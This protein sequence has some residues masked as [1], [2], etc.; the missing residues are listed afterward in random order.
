MAF[1]EAHGITVRET[2]SATKIKKGAP[3]ALE[4]LDGMERLVAVR[5][6]KRVEFDLVSERP[7]EDELLKHM[8]GPTGNLRAPTLKRGKQ[9]LVGFQAESYGTFLGV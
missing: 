1:F 8:L 7:P 2:V 4:L 3:E 5:G 9:I 6:K